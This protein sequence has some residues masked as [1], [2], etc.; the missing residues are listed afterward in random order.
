VA[1]SPQAWAA[2][3]PL[4]LLQATLG[5]GFDVAERRLLFDRPR[6]PACLDEV[7]LRGIAIAG[8]SIDVWIR[9]VG[10]EAAISVI[11]RDGPVGIRV[12][13]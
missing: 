1:C 4:A 5:I 10:D 11:G 6:L 9:R 7:T 3:A 2:A 12:T 8:G 13:S